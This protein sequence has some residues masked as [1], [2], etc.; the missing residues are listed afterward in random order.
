MK[1]GRPCTDQIAL[2]LSLPWEYR[3][4][5]VHRQEEGS[6]G[7]HLPHGLTRS[8]VRAQPHLLGLRAQ[9]H[10]RRFIQVAHLQHLHLGNIRELQEQAALTLHLLHLQL[11]HGSKPAHLE[12]LTLGAP[13]QMHLLHP[14]QATLEQPTRILM[15]DTTHPMGHLHPHLRLRLA[16]YVQ[17]GCQSALPPWVGLYHRITN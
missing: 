8:P 16:G 7:R 15:L 17:L 2:P 3:V 9:Q 11:R 14:H 1:S 6:Q 10:L 4:T 13:L 12:L 5:M